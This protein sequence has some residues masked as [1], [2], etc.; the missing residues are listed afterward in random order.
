MRYLKK[1]TKHVYLSS[2]FTV[3]SAFAA[4]TSFVSLASFKSFTSLVSFESFESLASLESFVSRD[5][6]ASLES[7]TSFESFESEAVSVAAVAE[8]AVRS[9]LSE[10]DRSLLDDDVDEVFDLANTTET[11]SCTLDKIEWYSEDFFCIRN[12][13]LDFIK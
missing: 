11:R 7:L 4:E 2:L 9:R 10:F 13:V 1:T 8:E 6:F 12:I 5:S 3:G